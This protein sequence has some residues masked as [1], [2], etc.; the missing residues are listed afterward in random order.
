[1]AESKEYQELSESFAV[2][3][4]DVQPKDTE[5]GIKKK[6]IQLQFK[7]SIRSVSKINNHPRSIN[8]FHPTLAVL[9]CGVNREVILL[10]AADGSIPFEDWKESQV[11]LQKRP[12]S[13][14][15]FS[16]FAAIEWN[17]SFNH[18]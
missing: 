10:S 12:T 6:G 16:Y 18:V 4:D 8:R 9:A 17:V 2:Y 1:M 7:E 15:E 3:A 13:D 11:K 5:C 14:D